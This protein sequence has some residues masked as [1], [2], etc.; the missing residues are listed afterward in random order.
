MSSVP[1]WAVGVAS[2]L[3][4]AVKLKDLHTFYHCCRVGRRTRLLAR[5]M[6]L[7]EY[8]QTVLEFSGLF[9]DIGK[10]GI[11]ENILLKPGRL[12]DTEM[13]L[14]KKHP[15]MSAEIIEKF[16]DEKFFRF[17]LPGIK[18]HHERF[19][20]SGYPFNIQGENIPLSARIIAI[21]DSMDAMT[22]TRPYREAL[23]MSMAKKELVDFSGSQFDKH[24]V[25]IYLDSEKYWEPMESEAQEV[26]VGE[27]LRVA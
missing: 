21:I 1:E 6:G 18:C 12:D 15:Q 26:A 25:R 24:I 10:V 27:V 22:H 20:G 11:S 14:I 16:A 23:S 3:L 9:H 19:D 17:L 2:A 4:H 8:Q 13:D 5:S 7:D